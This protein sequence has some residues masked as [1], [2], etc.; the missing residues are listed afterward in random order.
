[1]NLEF[2]EYTLDVRHI[3]NELFECAA[4]CRAADAALK[5]H[6]LARR[7][8][9]DARVR[10]TTIACDHRTYTFVDLGVPPIRTSGLAAPVHR[11]SQS[12]LDA[13]VRFHAR[14]LRRKEWRKLLGTLRIT[15][16][17]PDEGI[18]LGHCPIVCTRTE[19]NR[20][21]TDYAD[22]PRKLHR[23]HRSP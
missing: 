11:A 7:R 15:M 21:A 14:F 16:S 10:E 3:S 8:D 19:R 13:D 6:P 22:A 4:L 20:H 18:E 5:R 9:P 2:V 12:A 17:R 23:F 1:M